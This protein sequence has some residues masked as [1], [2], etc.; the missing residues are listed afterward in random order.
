MS[1]NSPYGWDVRVIYQA[2]GRFQ[3]QFISERNGHVVC[4]MCFFG[5][6]PHGED[7]RS[8]CKVLLTDENGNFTKSQCC[9]TWREN[10]E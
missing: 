1:Y 8:D 3:E 9:C 6:H 7:Y 10:Y 4:R 5:V 2:A